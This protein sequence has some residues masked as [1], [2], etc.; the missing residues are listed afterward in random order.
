MLF[1][2]DVCLCLEVV[3]LWDAVERLMPGMGWLLIGCA[4]AVSV[5]LE[6]PTRPLTAEEREELYGKHP[7][8]DDDG[9]DL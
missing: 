8:L 1:A 7:Y 6:I 5:V 2:L 3:Y 4:V 9:R